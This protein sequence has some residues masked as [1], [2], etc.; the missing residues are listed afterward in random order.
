MTNLY[1]H[2]NSSKI[3]INIMISIT[4]AKNHKIKYKTIQIHHF[5]LSMHDHEQ[6]QPVHAFKLNQQLKHQNNPCLYQDYM[7]N[8]QN[9][10]KQESKSKIN[11]VELGFTHFGRVIG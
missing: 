3:N 2:S 8:N 1:L 9:Q 7:I 10:K 11:K 5:N 4:N 6:S